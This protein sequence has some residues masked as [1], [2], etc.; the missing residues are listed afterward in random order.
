MSDFL[1]TRASALRRFAAR[2]GAPYLAL[3]LV[4]LAL[5]A[6]FTLGTG[7]DPMYASILDNYTLWGFTVQ[8]YY[9]WSARSLVEAALCVVEALPTVLWRVA[10][11]LLIALCAYLAARI[12][13]CEKNADAGW[14]L[15]G[16]ALCYDWTAM[17]TAGWVCTTL[18]FVWP[19]AAALA[20]AGITGAMHA[21]DA[22]VSKCACAGWKALKWAR[23]RW[24]RGRWNS[25]WTP[26][27][28][29]PLGRWCGW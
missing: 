26:S 9:T 17:R 22:T 19:L 4:L 29:P 12:L 23:A 6:Q 24:M 21:A 8:H 27:S 13:G 28:P 3:A 2:P 7:D 20:A 1:R 10:D 16:L 14:A 18:V 15:A 11:P 5:H 25:W